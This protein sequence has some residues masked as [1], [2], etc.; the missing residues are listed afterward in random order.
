MAAALAF[1]LSATLGTSLPTSAQ[2]ATA[3]DQAFPDLSAKVA[4]LQAAPDYYEPTRNLAQH[5]GYEAPTRIVDH[6]SA[7][8]YMVD[9]ASDVIRASMEMSS[10]PAAVAT[11]T[12][13]QRAVVAS[14]DFLPAAQASLDVL[15]QPATKQDIAALLG[16]YPRIAVPAACCDIPTGVIAQAAKF[17]GGGVVIAGGIAAACVGTAG[18][19]CPAAVIIGAGATVGLVATEGV[20]LVNEVRE[21]ITSSATTAPPVCAN[22]LVCS[23]Q[24]TITTSKSIMSV[25]GS[26]NFDGNAKQPNTSYGGSTGSNAN[27]QYTRTSS[28]GGVAVYSASHNNADDAASYTATARNFI[29][30]ATLAAGYFSVYLSDGEIVRALPGAAQLV[31]KPVDADCA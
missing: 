5:L 19:G 26:F 28:S 10:N 16:S 25:V 15:S 1:V 4:S 22:S 14:P 24:G 6:A 7:A 12:P 9:F 13:S 27:V 23:Q 8:A 20:G 18:F 17:F 11:L 30:C 2:A 3:D 31:S 29:R 21:Y